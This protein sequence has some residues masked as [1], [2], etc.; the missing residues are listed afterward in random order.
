MNSLAEQ[1][2]KMSDSQFR[3]IHTVTWRE[4]WPDKRGPEIENVRRLVAEAI[5]DNGR[6]I[7]IPARATQEGPERKFLAG[8]E[9]ELGSGFAPHPEFVRWVEDQV[10]KGLAKFK[11]PEPP[12]AACCIDRLTKASSTDPPRCCHESRA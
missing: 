10:D 4:D 6:A 3:G 1:M 7:V 12:I 8:L 2:K 9:F 5:Q 11:R